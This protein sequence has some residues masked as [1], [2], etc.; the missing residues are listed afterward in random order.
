MVF[1]RA[2]SK[3]PAEAAAALPIRKPS[4]LP[5]AAPEP[6][7]LSTLSATPIA[8][9][10]AW[11]AGKQDD[12]DSNEE[13][14]SHIKAAAVRKPSAL[15]VR[16]QPSTPLL[17]QRR[18]SANVA[19]GSASGAGAAPG[20]G[21]PASDTDSEDDA[22]AKSRTVRRRS[23]TPAAKTAGAGVAA[24]P[25]LRSARPSIAAASPAPAAAQNE[26]DSEEERW[27]R[28][29]AHRR[30]AASPHG[31]LQGGERH[32]LVPADSMQSD[33]ALPPALKVI[34]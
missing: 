27:Q 23:V 18:A 22:W 28:A 31:T 32:C 19:P 7:R 24:A 3:M 25:A 26:D 30:S 8:A 1:R 6:R 9:K 17:Q 2:Q 14:W 13:Q 4:A 16:A 20:Q 11:A 5:A 10:N 12:A 34:S 15:P 29:K 21:T 33:A